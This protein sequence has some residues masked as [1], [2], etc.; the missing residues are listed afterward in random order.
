MGNA[1]LKSLRTRQIFCETNYCIGAK[2]SVRS[3]WDRPTVQGQTELTASG[4]DR[5]LRTFGVEAKIFNNSWPRSGFI[6]AG[7]GRVAG[8]VQG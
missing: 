1:L 6:L 2:L 5:P 7:V 3:A 8:R 4:R